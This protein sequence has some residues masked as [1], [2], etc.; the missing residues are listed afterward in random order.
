MTNQDPELNPFS[1]AEYDK[2]WSSC[3]DFIKYNPGARH[4]RRHILS[5]LKT[6]QF[7]TVLDVG[8]GNNVS[9]G[10]FT[11]LLREGAILGSCRL[12]AKYVDFKLDVS[13]FRGV[14][15]SANSKI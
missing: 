10:S 1:A 7:Q 11:F 5:L 12:A 8:C 9:F 14:G 2:L 4:R 3:D 6:I 13:D 15:N